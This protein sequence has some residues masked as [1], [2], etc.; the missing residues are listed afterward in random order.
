MRK[1]DVVEL[2]RGQGFV[3]PG[4]PTIPRL[5]LCAGQA[6]LDLHHALAEIFEGS[7]VG[8]GR[9]LEMQADLETPRARVM[10]DLEVELRVAVMELGQA[11]VAPGRL[12]CA[13]LLPQLRL[14]ALAQP[15]EEVRGRQ[16]RA[17]CQL[18]EYSSASNS[19]SSAHLQ[20]PRRPGAVSPHGIQGFRG[21]PERGH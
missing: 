6:R 3:E 5:E 17:T 1:N 4:P 18:S 21:D 19:G 8:A 10:P 16:R 11:A 7:L 15:G 12:K 2:R 20:R 9:A 14:D 13:Q